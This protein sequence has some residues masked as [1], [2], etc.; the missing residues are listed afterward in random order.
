MIQEIFAEAAYGVRVYKET[1]EPYDGYITYCYLKIFGIPDD[2]TD[3]EE[4]NI[5]SGEI[6]RAV[7]IGT[8][9][10]LLIL[11][12]QA[13]RNDMDRLKTCSSFGNSDTKPRI[14]NNLPMFLLRA[15]QTFPDIIADC[16]KPLPYEKS[17]HQKVKEGM[18]REIVNDYMNSILDE[19]D[20]KDTGGVKLVLDE[21]QQNYLLGRRIKGEGYPE[22]AKDNTAWELYHAA[23]FKEHLNTR[24]P[25]NVCHNKC[26]REG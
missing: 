9:T 10:G 8:V 23:G 12:G 5:F 13:E 18:V 17:I 25:F 3:D 14:L 20:Q 1:D 4:E 26:L 7:Q 6:G 15:Y 2:L 21:D 16:P 11:G 24:V 19:R 22:S